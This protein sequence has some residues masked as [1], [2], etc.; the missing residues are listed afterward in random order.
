[1]LADGGHYERKM[2]HLQK[3]KEGKKRLRAMSIGNVELPQEAFSAVLSMEGGVA[4]KK[5]K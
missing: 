3:Q 5:G 4:V 2:K 1:M